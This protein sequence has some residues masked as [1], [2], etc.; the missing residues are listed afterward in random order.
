VIEVVKGYVIPAYRYSF[1]EAQG[2][3]TFDRWVTDYIIQYADETTVTLSQIKRSARRPL[4]NANASGWEGEQM[5]LNAMYVL[6]K[7]NWVKR[8]DDGTQEHRGVAQWAIN[9]AI[10]EEFKEY[11]KAVIDAKQHMMDTIYDK[12]P[13]KVPRKNAHGSDK[14]ELG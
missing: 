3:S 1:G 10:M 4:E 6:E 9:P 12:Q 2:M 11:R 8:I 13:V 14:H 7:A 5:I